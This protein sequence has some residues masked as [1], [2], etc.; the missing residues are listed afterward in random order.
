M[1]TDVTLQPQAGK[2]LVTHASKSARSGG[3]KPANNGDNP[4]ELCRV[5]RFK[6]NSP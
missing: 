6:E 4:Q 5:N 2:K 3:D 1:R